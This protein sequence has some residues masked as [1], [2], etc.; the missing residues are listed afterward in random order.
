MKNDIK[1][2]LIVFGTRPEI[3]KLAPLILALKNSPLKNNFVTVST[4]QHEELL[5][6]QLNYWKI[7]PDYFITRNAYGDNLTRLLSHTLSGLQ[8]IVDQIATIEYIIVQG[9]TN[10]A[11]AAANL[12]FLNQLKLIH[13]EAGLRSFDYKNPFPEEFNRIVASKAA[14]FHFAPTEMTKNNLIKEGI[15][16]TKIMVVGNTII[17]ALYHSKS[18]EGITQK[19]Q[20]IL[21]TLH[22]RENIGNMYLNLIEIIEGLANQHH[23]LNFIWITHPNSSDK[24]KS[25]INSI[26]NLQII[27][28]LPYNEYIDL[29]SSA[30][31]VITDSGGVT[32]EAIHLGLPIIVF[33]KTTERAEPIEENYPMIVSTD[34]DEI[35]SFFENNLGKTNTIQYS[36][37]QGNTSQ[38][39]INWLV[40]E[41]G[42]TN[43]DTVIV[44]GGPAG[45][46]LLLKTIKDG[47]KS[48]FFDRRIALIEKS[49]QLIKGNLT[50]YNV[51]SDTLSNV[52]LE[53]LEGSTAEFI[54]TEK[55][56]NEIDFIKSYNGKSIPLNKLDSYYSKLG[57]LLQASLES[58]N[59]C[60]FIMNTTVNKVV[61]KQNGSYEVFMSDKKE[62][63]TTKQIIIATGGA[64]QTITSNNTLFANSISLLSYQN[65]SILSDTLL[66]SGLPEN[67]SNELKKKRKVVILGGSHSAL[68]AAH[69]LLNSNNSFEYDDGDIQIWT[70]S[71]PKV[72]FDN[73]EAAE[74]HGYND[75]N[76][77]DFCPIT[78]KL[79]RLAGLRM[80]GRDLYMKM[81]GLNNL[82]KE[83]RVIIN[84]FKNRVAEIEEAL[85]NAAVIVVAFGY[86]LNIFPFFDKDGVE[87]KFLGEQTNHWVSDDCEL[88]DI[89]GNVIKQVFAS[90]LATGFIPKG[91]LGG[92]P[93]FNGQT[94]GIW[95]YQ[96]ATAERIIN[97]LEPVDK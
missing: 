81:L 79:Y 63:I 19:N 51:N 88:L 10:T 45:T 11:L 16:R 33:R 15:D 94:N 95:Y 44:G 73:K 13:I 66:K 25:E 23:E 43:Y 57:N 80:D 24:I 96:N 59:K 41:T 83:N 55:L 71:L 60:N 21:I 93:S 35:V 67:L 17:D 1:N 42:T 84:L 39:I 5:D 26:Q 64:A 74:M 50:Q 2:I 40:D 76:D 22:R 12:S 77:D 27:D 36:Y 8:D 70:T 4:S 65:K 53:C 20:H 9:D 69:V 58:A 31:I 38:K 75:F 28:H 82:T 54:E 30:K 92:E 49:S 32:E 46:G 85:K 34:K 47:N 37:G 87:I 78:K 91:D 61:Q 68:S 48:T 7:A 52:F 90:G 62:P 56:K 18:Y 14:Y 97:N 72:Y 3:I 6:E 89:N 86:K 29:Y